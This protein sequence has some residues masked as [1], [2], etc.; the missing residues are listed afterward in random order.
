MT[1]DPV[2][3]SWTRLSDSLIGGI[4]H[5][6]SNRIATLSALSELMRMDDL[7][8]EN[9]DMLRKEVGRLELLVQHLRLLGDES[10]APAEALHL[11][12]VTAAAIALHKYHRDFR[13]VTVVMGGDIMVQPVHVSRSR[14]VRVLLMLIAASAVAAGQE[15][16]VHAD[17]SAEGVLVRVKFGPDGAARW[18]AEPSDVLLDGARSWLEDGEGSISRD[19]STILLELPSLAEVRKRGRNRS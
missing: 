7:P 17:V 16:A 1:T 15:N 12:E 18:S 10:A 3:D 2:F 6:L 13:D 9:A 14:L 11:P 5:A 19:G 4:A 8:A